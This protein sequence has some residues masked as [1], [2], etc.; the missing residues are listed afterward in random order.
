MTGVVRMMI[1]GVLL[2]AGMVLEIAQGDYL[3]GDGRVRFTVETIV[4]Q[5]RD[6]DCDWVILTGIEKRPHGGPWRPRRLQVRVSALSRSLAAPAT[7]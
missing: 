1:G 7:I 3:Y 2:G 6:W 4:G 5:R